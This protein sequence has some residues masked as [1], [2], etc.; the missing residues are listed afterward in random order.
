MALVIVGGL[1]TSMALNRL[2]LPTL[3]LQFGKFGVASDPDSRH[4]PSP[5]KHQASPRRST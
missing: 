2:V 5:Q 1:A 4:R 3:V